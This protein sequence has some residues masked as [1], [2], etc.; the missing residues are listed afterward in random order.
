MKLIIVLAI[1]LILSACGQS[2][3]GNSNPQ[4]AI[5]SNGAVSPNKPV[6]SIWTRDTDGATLDFRQLV[7]GTPFNI[8]LVDKSTETCTCTGFFIGTEDLGTYGTSGCTHYS[9]GPAASTC[10]SHNGT[11]NYQRTTTGLRFVSAAGTAD[12]H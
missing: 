11:G 9:G 12:F 8:F 10:S 2:G 6:A 5:S 1:G 3:G 4:P 7:L